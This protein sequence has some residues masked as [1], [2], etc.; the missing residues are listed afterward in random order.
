[1]GYVYADVEITNVKEDGGCFSRS[2]LVDTG[3]Y[4]TAIPANELEKIGVEREYKETYKL[5]NGSP[6]S[7]DVGFALIS[8]N[9]RKVAGNVV[10]GEVGSEPLIGVLTLE[11]ARFAVDPVNQKLINGKTPRL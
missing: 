6:V 9:G 3:A 11:A 10:F 5:A 1:M 2:I 8:I 7:Y 4:D